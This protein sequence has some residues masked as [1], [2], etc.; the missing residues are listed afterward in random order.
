[1]T[2]A[3]G[4]YSPGVIAE[5]LS[6]FSRPGSQRN[7]SP[8]RSGNSTFQLPPM[9]SAGRLR[10]DAL[11]DTCDSV[12]R[13]EEGGILQGDVVLLD[14]IRTERETVYDEQVCAGTVG[15]VRSISWSM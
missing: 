2:G 13:V 7:N 14:K 1:M 8:E 4:I 5:L 3:G 15:A 11:K 9:G 10:R 6:S 12:C